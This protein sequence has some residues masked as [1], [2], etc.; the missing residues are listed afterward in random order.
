MHVEGLRIV[1]A[2]TFGPPTRKGIENK[3]RFHGAIVSGSVSGKT[4]LLIVGDKGGAKLAAAKERGIP[5][6]D[7]AQLK[8]LF[9]GATFEEVRDGVVKPS[10]EPEPPGRPLEGVKIVLTGTF[11]GL[12]RFEI[13]RGLSSL[14]ASVVKTISGQ[15]QLLVAGARAGSKIADAEKR[16]IPVF[17]Q[18]KLQKVLD[19]TPWK[20]LL[21]TTPETDTSEAEEA[22]EQPSVPFPKARPLDGRWEETSPDGTHISG[23]FRRGL[24]DGRWTTTTDDSVVEEHWKSG[25]R[26]GP[27]TTTGEAVVIGH[28]HEGKESGT[29]EYYF[30]SGALQERIEF[31]GGSREGRYESFREDGS[32]AAIGEYRGGHR[33]GTWTWFDD[34]RFEK[35]QR[36]Y[37]R[38]GKDE[39]VAWYPGGQLGF[40]YFVDLNSDKVGLEEG[41]YPDGKP[42]FRGSWING[43]GDGKQLSWSEDGE[44]S[45]VEY[46]KGLSLEMRSD[47]AK[48]TKVA[49]KLKKAKDSYQKSDA[50]QGAVGYKLKKLYLLFLWESGNY[51]VPSDP[52]LWGEVP[53]DAF[54]GEMLLKF[55]SEV[56]EGKVTHRQGSGQVEL[57]RALVEATLNELLREF[58]S[59]GA[60]QSIRD[61][62]KS[63]PP[64]TQK[65]VASCLVRFGED[66]GDVLVGQTAHVAGGLRSGY[67][68]PSFLWPND[69]RTGLD[70]VD[71]VDA[72]TG[73]M[74]V[75]FRDYL[76]ALGGIE[77]W[78]KL[79]KKK[80]K[81]EGTIQFGTFRDVVA[82][83]TAEEMKDYL[84]RISSSEQGAAAHVHNALK[85][86][87]YTSEEL[88]DIACGFK[89]PYGLQW[90]AI[91]S[92]IVIHHE[93]GEAI[94]EKLVD[95]LK[96]ETDGPGS[97]SGWRGVSTPHRSLWEK[98]AV[99]DELL[100]LERW[101]WLPKHELLRQAVRS[102]S[103]EQ[104]RRVFLQHLDDEYESR[105]ALANLYLD[106]SPLDGELLK[107][108][109]KAFAK[110]PFDESAFGLGELG[111]GVL[112]TLLKEAPKAKTKKRQRGYGWA[113]TVA[114]ARTLMDGGELD[115]A[116]DEFIRFDYDKNEDHYE[117][118][119]PY[120]MRL[121]H[122]LP[123]D[124]A[125][126]ILKRGL[127]SPKFHRVFPCLGSHPDQDLLELA[128]SLALKAEDTLKPSER[129][130]IGRGLR[131]LPECHSWIEWMLRSGGGAGQLKWAF[132]TA[133]GH[134]DLEKLKARLEAQGTEVAKV[135]D[136]PA[137]IAKALQN[138]GGTGETLYLLRRLKGAPQDNLN[139]VYGLPKGIG[140]ERW[141]TFDGDPMRHLFTVDLATVPELQKK[142]DGE[143]RTFSVFI[144]SPNHNEAWRPGTEETAVVFSTEAQIAEQSAPAEAKQVWGAV[145]FEAV[146]VQVSPKL[147]QGR[148]REKRQVAGANARIG[149]KPI[150]LQNSEDCGQFLMQFGEGFIDINLGDS[151][152]MYVFEKTAFWQS[153]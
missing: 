3:L 147:W 18:E 118:L 4:Q 105:G 150:W 78:R 81:T 17:G 136:N 64:M 132:E 96:L 10:A 16:G 107:A 95:A 91:C 12:S 11:K 109:I 54:S 44:E 108:A 148:S 131:G 38:S 93:R 66:V 145:G 32:K 106:E 49:A 47:L 1:L 75:Q 2:G 39:H 67:L 34:G 57:P 29:W 37:H 14:G 144:S 94:P 111:A 36:N 72:S 53:W 153:L 103:P 21:E 92:A 98:P 122:R 6:F 100:S 56:P 27:C 84:D 101:V 80:A 119:E 137:R 19:G 74:S 138:A 114:A 90:P 31:A 99:I 52:D 70:K 63:L 23:T 104:R 51:N 7:Q 89:T 65:L 141:P 135:L 127:E 68:M 69:A 20:D 73:E 24:R 82:S 48:A 43:M 115:P 41:F 76:N 134:D 46:C 61:G 83:A 58:A 102:L 120:M 85:A 152:E 25:V 151:G 40:R 79:L 77:V 128:M 5:V 35:V 133:I 117:S 26:H 140:E 59:D 71:S 9:E 15:T 13:S 22:F 112:P 146:S 42:K 123:K 121:V 50:L 88:V 8:L 28:F 110:K 143:Q 45:A 125:R 149:G 116:C 126:A 55:L 130:F 97:T 30:A 124:R 139:Q 87:D 142:L 129:M 33:S 86:N 62:W 60:D 113:L